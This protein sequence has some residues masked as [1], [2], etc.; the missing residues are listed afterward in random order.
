MAE[1]I[2]VGIGA[3]CALF[4]LGLLGMV[5][6]GSRNRAIGLLTVCSLFL[7][8]LLLVLPVCLRFFIPLT[9][10]LCVFAAAVLAW[11]RAKWCKLPFEM[12]PLGRSR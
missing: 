8:G 12:L 7:L 5:V 2:L 10:T 4:V 3:W 1:W 9:P 11:T 6:A